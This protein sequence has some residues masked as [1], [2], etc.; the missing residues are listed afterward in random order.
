MVKKGKKNRQEEPEAED[1]DADDKPGDADEGPQS[2]RRKKAAR[3]AAQQAAP[4]APAAADI[5]DLEY[6]EDDSEEEPEEEIIEEG[7][8]VDEE[9]DDEEDGPKAVFRPGIDEIQEGEQLDFDPSTYDMFHRSQ[10]DWPCLSF[11]ILRDDLG[12]S[13][14][15]YPMTSYVVAGTQ[16]EK[17]EDNRIYMMKWSRLYRTNKDGREDSDD[18]SESSEE[19]EQDDH[20]ACLEVKAVPHPGAVNRIRA[21]PQ[22]GHIV[23]TWADTGKVHMWNMANHRKALDKPTEKP[24]ATVKPIFTCTSHKDEG[25]AMD[26][27]P[28]DTG[29]FLSG[30]NDGLIFLWEPVQGGWSVGS[31]TPFTAHGSGVEDV[32]WKRKGD[33][34]NSIFASCSSDHSFCVWDVRAGGHKKPTVHVKDAHEDHVN[35]LSWSPCVGELLV[36][37]S[38]DGGFKI[39][40]TRNTSAGPMANFQWHRKP[41]TSLDWHPT[42]ETMLV[43]SSEDDCVSIWDMAV[44]DD[45]EGRELPEGAEHYPAQLMFLHMGQ[46]DPKEV[47]WHPQLQGVCVSTAA[48]GFNIFKPCNV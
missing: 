31:N 7:D 43:V 11:D 40:D 39:W 47:R 34:C 15:T 29:R 23:A 33:G 4:S 22:V 35:V 27:S 2:K 21:L 24:P 42:D 9:E 41:I 25:F 36:T 16:A 18:D 3:A 5:P 1:K 8:E 12:A 6:D 17:V 45:A 10:V 32:H 19:G 48:T 38:D 46:K 28:T 13:R 44:E 37:G 14:T 20:E 26:W 30:G